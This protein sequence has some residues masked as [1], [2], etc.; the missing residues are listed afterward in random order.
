[1]PGASPSR[2]QQRAD[3]VGA[4]DAAAQQPDQE[5][6]RDRG[7]DELA[8]QRQH[9]AERRPSPATVCAPIVPATSTISTMPDHSSGASVAALRRLAARQRADEDPDEVA[10]ERRPRAR[11]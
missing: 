11:S 2:T 1:M 3:R 7:E 9:V 4:R 10:D 8:E 5:R 6:E